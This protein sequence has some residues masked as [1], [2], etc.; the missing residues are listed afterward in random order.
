MSVVTNIMITGLLMGEEEADFIN[1]MRKLT[2]PYHP[3][4]DVGN[5]FIA[6]DRNKE[7]SIFVGAF[8]YLDLDLLN[9]ALKGAVG[10]LER[11][12]AENMQIGRSPVGAV[13]GSDLDFNNINVFT[14]KW[15][16]V[17]VKPKPLNE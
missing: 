8:N 9:E 3:F 16:P 12:T 17:K 4:T 2:D 11:D 15:C 6:G 14:P 7:G 5:P 10:M 13:F 1:A